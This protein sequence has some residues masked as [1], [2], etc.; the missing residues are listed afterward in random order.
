MWVPLVITLWVLNLIVSTMDQ[1]LALLPSRWHPH[2]LLGRDV[3]GLGM[4]LTILVIFLTGLLTRNFLGQRLVRLW[5]A[6]LARIPIVNSI[7]SSVKQVSDTLFSPGGKAF[8][9]A[10][11][12][13][14]PRAGAWTIAF[15]TGVPADEIA[16]HLDGD[17]VSV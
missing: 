2:A 3:P 14:Y 13:Q 11:L 16:R 15:Q 17:M 10:L 4:L 1:S 7:Y 9:K 12:V 6:A 8:R 5:E